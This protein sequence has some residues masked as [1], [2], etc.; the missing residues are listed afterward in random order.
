MCVL[1]NTFLSNGSVVFAAVLVHP[2]FPAAAPGR[3]TVKVFQKVGKVDTKHYY[4]ALQRSG[5]FAGLQPPAT[6]RATQ[7]QPT[8]ALPSA[9]K[10]TMPA[11]Q[12][13]L[14]PDLITTGTPKPLNRA[15]APLLTPQVLQASNQ[16]LRVQ[17]AP[18]SLDL[19]QAQIQNGSQ[20][21]AV[22]GDVRLQVS[23][24]SG[25]YKASATVLGTYDINVLDHN[26]RV[27]HGIAVRQP[28]QYT[29]HYQ[30]GE[31][32]ALGLDP[33]RL[34]LSWPD[35]IATAL[36]HKQSV[37]STRAFV[38]PVINDPVAHTLTAQT[39][40]APLGT[41][42]VASSP[43]LQ[44]P[45]SPSM[46]SVSGNS[47]DFSVSYPVQ[48]APGPA[49]F[50]PE[51]GFEYSSADPN[52][53]H[54][55]LSP[56]DQLGDGWSLGL[57]SVSSETEPTGSGGPGTWY[58]LSIPGHTSDRLIPDPKNVGLYYTL[59]LS[60]W[61][62]VGVG[63]TSTNAVPS[64]FQAWDP[65]GMYYKF[66]CTSDSLEYMTDSTGTRTNY[67]WGVDRITAPTNGPNLPQKQVTYSY[68]Q[69]LITPGGHTTVSDSA[70]AQIVYKTVD[71]STTKIIGTIDFSYKAPSY[72]LTVPSGASSS[73]VQPYTSADCTGTPPATSTFKLRCDDPLDDGAVKAPAVMSLFSLST[74]TSYVGADTDQKPAYSYSMS[75]T[76]TPLSQIN[77]PLTWA[78]E[79]MTGEHLLTSITPTAYTGGTAHALK[80]YVFRY[81]QETNH[82][83]DLDHTLQQGPLLR[84]ACRRRSNPTAT[85]A[86]P[87]VGRRIQRMR[88]MTSLAMRLRPWMPLGRP[89]ADCIVVRG[90]HFPRLPRMH[91]P[92]GRQ[93]IIL[94]VR[95]MI[96]MKPNPLICGTCSINIRRSPMITRREAWQ[97]AR[98]I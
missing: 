90:A 93:D 85:V 89:T 5:N 46:G 45:T 2:S 23:Q 84:S 10:A 86:L 75:Y 49:G 9:G 39:T 98:R 27:V 62:I 68:F 51:L 36:Q 79:Y 67:K 56:A 33:D 31:L 81:T 71:G 4:G 28:I 15:E 3:N 72:S 59:H 94:P 35:Q 96:A 65:S 24:R 41:L 29:F 19:S 57:P 32:S 8:K 34:Y 18:N 14:S 20:S 66:G 69:D 16:Q 43:D 80:P 58:T 76:N 47:G 12:Q 78:L 1:G 44:A 55:Q 13:T 60:H 77:D 87:A 64:C 61:R 82:Y 30:P 83:S 7:P 95:G 53:R 17:I 92:P 42:V 11:F 6:D 40:V 74:L 52:G 48:V 73:W 22:S 50:K 91:Q 97:P 25:H 54:S 38:T 63:V 88:C 21:G 70:V 26:G 37:Q